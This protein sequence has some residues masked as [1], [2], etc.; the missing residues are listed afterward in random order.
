MVLVLFLMIAAAIIVL[1][2]LKVVKEKV[3][4]VNNFVDKAEK[5]I[6][7]AST[8]LTLDTIDSLKLI[9]EKLNKLF[10]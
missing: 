6:D 2:R 5:F 4:K 8:T 1:P 9:L 3:E 10:P 7:R